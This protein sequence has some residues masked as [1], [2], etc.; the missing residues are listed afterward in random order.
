MS[1]YSNFKKHTLEWKYF[2]R[3]N[4]DYFITS[5]VNHEEYNYWH[6]RIYQHCIKI[7]KAKLTKLNGE[8]DNSK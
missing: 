1:G 6:V 5:K 7:S 4:E 3:N 2:T 8:I